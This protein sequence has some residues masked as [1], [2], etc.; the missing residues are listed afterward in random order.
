VAHL[1]ETPPQ[2]YQFSQ[3]ATLWH[4]LLQ[5]GMKPGRPLRPLNYLTITG[6]TVLE[7]LAIPQRR[8]GFCQ[9]GPGHF[10]SLRKPQSFRRS[11]YED[12][13]SRGC[14]L[15]LAMTYCL[16]ITLLERR[17]MSNTPINTL[18]KMTVVC[19]F[20]PDV[21]VLDSASMVP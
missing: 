16:Y 11:T 4:H 6:A 5:T 17:S 9:E 2:K 21:K 8:Q 20:G 13:Q 7:R 3:Q 10:P 18:E 12:R 14:Q 15:Y 19:Y 1:Q